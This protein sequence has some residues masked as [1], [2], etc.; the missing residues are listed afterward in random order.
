M[1]GVP[2][3]FGGPDGSN[4]GDPGL[5]YAALLLLLQSL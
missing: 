4:V 2:Y 5:D 3:S 1:L